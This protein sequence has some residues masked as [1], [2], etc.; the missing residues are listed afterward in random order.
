MRLPRTDVL[1]P[2]DVYVLQ[3]L[4]PSQPWRFGKHQHDGW[5][6]LQF[7]VEGTLHQQVN[8]RDED[9]SA[10]DLLLIRRDDEHVL[11][12][13]DFLLFNLAIPDSEWQRL[14]EYLGGSALTSLLEQPRPPRLRIVGHE[15]TRI[16]ADLRQLFTAQRTPQARIL[17]ARLLLNLLP[18][19][20]PALTPLTNDRLPHAHAPAPAW[21]RS[22]IDDL[23]R[24]IDHGTD[25][26][27]L[28]ARARVSPEHFARS[29]RRHLGIT[30]TA[31]L[32]RRRLER[33]ALLLS[34]SDRSV[35]DIALDLGF[36]SASAFSR[37]FRA[38]H[39]SSP[40][41]WRL[42]HGVGFSA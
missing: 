25:P 28:A 20:S 39:A 22:V 7:V 11:H 16:E 41:A 15:R 12:G 26:A 31:L 38:H 29:V 19:M 4:G 24:L 18:R 1:R 42:K 14:S 37:S 23:D 27:R 6:E 33:A 21:L 9:L 13:R 10:G 30:P 17:V 32:N 5:S 36:G 3:S 8:G 34:H 2:G 35:L 40:R